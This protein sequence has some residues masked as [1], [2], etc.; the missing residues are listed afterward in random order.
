MHSWSMICKGTFKE[1]V[2]GPIVPIHPYDLHVVTVRWRGSS[3]CGGAGKYVPST[4][5]IPTSVVQAEIIISLS[6]TPS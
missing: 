2:K 3:L 4:I 6:F 5:L 1:E